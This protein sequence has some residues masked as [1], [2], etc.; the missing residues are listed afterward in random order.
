M[1][2]IQQTGA[3]ALVLALLLLFLW[4]LRKRGLV[5]VGGSVPAVRRNG[6]RSLERLERLP[7]GPQHTLHLVRM[8]G[9]ALLISASPSGCEVLHR[10]DLREIANSGDVQ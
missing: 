5:V 9:S 7:L 8:G 4:W 2:T 1:E 10:S 6:T 3:V